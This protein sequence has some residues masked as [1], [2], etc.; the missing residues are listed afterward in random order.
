M[1]LR[2]RR[3]RLHAAVTASIFQRR[4]R[5]V[6]T[7]CRCRLIVVLTIYLVVVVFSCQ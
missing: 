6:P 4:R 2:Q 7:S 1:S 5:G 3:R